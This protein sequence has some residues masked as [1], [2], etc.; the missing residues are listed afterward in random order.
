MRK[1]I[2]ILSCDLIFNCVYSQ[3]IPSQ[4]TEY[5]MRK[6]EQQQFS[7]SLK[8]NYLLKAVIVQKGIDLEIAVYKKGD[9]VVQAYFD[10]PNGE[11]GPEPV[12]FVSPESGD[13]FL[14]IKQIT[15]DTTTEGKYSIRLISILPV[16]A[17]IDTSFASGS[18]IQI[19]ELTQLTIENLTNLGML[20]GFL[21][22]HLPSIARSDYNWDAELFRVMP[23]IVNAKT[24]TEAN[25]ALEK[26]VDKLGKPELCSLCKGIT[27]DS[28]VKLMPDYGYLFVQGNLNNSLVEK[29]IYIRNNRNQ[30]EN[31]YVQ[32][33][34]GIGNPKFDNEKPY[35][36][37]VYP[38]VGY[39]LLALY[40]Y[41]NIIQYFF[42]YRYLI[43]ADWNNIL[44]EF[45]PRFINA[46]DS[47]AYAVTCLEMVSRVHDTHANIWGK[48]NALDNYFGHYRAPLRADFIG[49][50]LVVTGYYSKTSTEIEKVK[51][52]DVILKINKQPV[53]QLVEKYLPV[54]PASNYERQLW[55]LAH[56][57]FRSNLESMDLEIL[58]NT[59][60]LSLKVACIAYDKINMGSDFNPDPM[61]SSYKIIDG[62]IGYLFAGRYKDSQLV[63]IK[64]A[65]EHT[66]GLIIDMRTYPSDFMPFTFCPFIKPDSSPFVKFT[67]GDVNNP[68]LFRFGQRI[69][70][71]VKNPEYYKGPVI[72]LV[73]SIT[74]S[75]AEYTTMAL[76][77]APHVTVIGSTT[78]G[79]DG[80]VSPIVLPGGIT[81]YISGIGVYYP[82][83]GET[84]RKGIRIDM[85]VTPTIE[86]I[87]KGK[88]ELLEKAV[89]IINAKN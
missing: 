43:G 56:L 73:N 14:V 46:K 16:H 20:W 7:F 82:D 59:Q 5:S 36:L 19:K 10:S 24:K 48:N 68:G 1:L 80:N 79:A 66:R 11:N 44:P 39:R 69:S 72:E 63:N 75:Q 88:D 38:D 26:W 47:T 41:W 62:G 32:K 55:I 2:L 76:Q 83:G 64:K 86:G 81:T 65:F 60:N 37:M 74:L 12:A 29:L 31:Y 27:A 49:N 85:Q 17:L 50:K 23:E 30:E 53:N 89:E 77:S 13:Y 8:K 58:R 78:A 45:V 54:S 28:Q 42:P 40:R 51:P 57:L 4:E 3:S 61:D 6:N 34:A 21:K 25:T 70:N 9:T 18:R 15:E 84:Q 87:T 35:T 67:I 52:G 22:Y 33:V 71:G